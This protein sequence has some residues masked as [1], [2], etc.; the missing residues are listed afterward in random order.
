MSLENILLDLDGN[1]KISNLDHYFEHERNF[2]PFR[3]DLIKLGFLIYQMI[4]G[5]ILIL[6]MYNRNLDKKK[7]F[8]QSNLIPD[9]HLN[10]LLLLDEKVSNELINLFK[11]LTLEKE[12]ENIQSSIQATLDIKNDPFLN[13]IDW[14]KLEN[15]E[16][17]SPF[18]PSDKEFN[19]KQIETE[20]IDIPDLK[21]K[22]V[23]E[24]LRKEF[25]I[26]DEKSFLSIELIRN[27]GKGGFGEV[28]LTKINEKC[29][30]LKLINK[31]NLLK[32][33]K[34]KSEPFISV[35]Y[36]SYYKE[37]T[38][39]KKVGFLGNECRFLV[40]LINSSQTESQK[41]LVDGFGFDNK[42]ATT[43]ELTSYIF[44]FMEF[45]NGGTLE[46]NL[47]NH[48]PAFNEKQVIFY[49]AQI[50]CAIL[51]LHNKQII[52][53]DIT[54]RNILLDSNGNAKLCDFSFCTPKIILN[55]NKS[56]YGCGV[57]GYKSPESYS[58]I[59]L[60]YSQDYW[61]FGICIFIMFT[62]SYPFKIVGDIRDYTKAIPNLNETR[63]RSQKIK[64]RLFKK[65]EVQISQ[66]ACDFVSKLLNKN[67][68]ERLVNKEDI[69]N[70]PFFSSIDWNKL[71]NGQIEPP[72]KPNTSPE[73]VTRLNATK[74]EANYRHFGLKHKQ[75]ICD[76]RK[77]PHKHGG[78]SKKEIIE[79]KD[80]D[81]NE[82]FVFE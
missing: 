59:F 66:I 20:N 2:T 74:F 37:L 76:H 12:L 7:Y 23:D 55:P 47:L 46:W 39:E 16:I 22:N 64:Y 1:C 45:L 52:H 54:L 78:K 19:F 14:V 10:E 63:K 35:D 51:F 60:D 61:S 17:Q 30:A 57:Y 53:Q 49:S 68:N 36:N 21:E 29:Y 65:D 80:F 73:D 24:Y 25:Q 6:D 28:F 62:R 32:K 3:R 56:R 38:M 33:S 67:I 75:C 15:G 43:Q 27:I 72:I 34:L 13:E 82:K 70:D 9:D 8:F 77:C 58:N 79:L 40:K 11:N 41:W 18:K 44:N 31:L 50:L 5:N 69:K 4:S 26:I 71:E 48:P 81:L 42:N